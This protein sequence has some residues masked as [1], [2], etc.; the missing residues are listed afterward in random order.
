MNASHT[1][2]PWQSE[3][4][5]DDTI[6]LFVP[7]PIGRKVIATIDIGFDEPWDSQQHANAAVMKAAPDLLDALKELRDR[8]VLV[9]ARLD[10]GLPD[11]A[12]VH[13]QSADLTWPLSTAGLAI[14]KAEGRS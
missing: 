7:A 10:A 9:K 2:G 5:G 11:G 6:E 1:Q 12:P 13:P 8:C 4:T 14:A 3:E